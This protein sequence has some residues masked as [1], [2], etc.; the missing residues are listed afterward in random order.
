M[1][2]LHFIVNPR[3]GNGRGKKC[4][5]QIEKYCRR[6]GAPYELHFTQ[7]RGDGERIA[8]ALTESDDAAFI[9]AVGGD[10]TFHE[11]LNGIRDPKSVTL[12]LLPAG[13][14]NDFARAA[15]LSRNVPDALNAM[16]SGRSRY[17][18]YIQCDGR[19]CL[20]VAGTGLDIDVLERV[21]GHKGKLK[22]L[23]SLLYCL[24]HFTPY[25]VRL[26]ANG[27][28]SDHDCIMA[29]VCNGIAIGG[30]ITLSPLSKIDDGKMNVIVMR[31]PDDG[32]LMRVVPKFVKG[33]HMDLPITTHVTCES[34]EIISYDGKPI[35][36]DGEIYRDKTLRCT[37][38]AGGL[39]AAF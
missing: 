33:K 25:K 30:G 37:L 18:D 22:Y 17:I 24:R 5:K 13:R 21:A 10:G 31:M 32:K 11:V 1:R 36:L 29:G 34:A 27:E 14:G 39:H 12:G 23:V 9:V 7:K 20:N 6:K 4:A 16:L 26:I 35:Q 8:A 15:H 38:V 3:S 19:R 2:T 28:T